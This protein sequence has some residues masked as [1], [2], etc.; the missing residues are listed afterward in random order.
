MKKHEADQEL[1][2]GDIKSINKLIITICVSAAVV[3][4][5]ILLNL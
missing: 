2:P 4:F 5:L 1:S 3:S